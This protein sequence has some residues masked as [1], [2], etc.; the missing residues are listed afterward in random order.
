MPLISAKTVA[1]ALASYRF[2]PSSEQLTAA[3]RWAKLIRDGLIE[4][5]RETALE[6]DFRR[7]IIEDILGYCSVGSGP[8]FTVATK[9]PVG[10]GEVDLALGRFSAAERK[11]L[12]PF[13]LK[14]PSFKN[15]D[16]IMPG[17]AKT[18]VQQAWEYG[19]DAIGA[20]WVLVSNQME[21]RLYA[22]GRGRRD[23]EV[24]D[25]S[26]LDDPAHLKR[27][28]MLLAE[29]NLLGSLTTSLLQR[30]LQEDKQITVSLYKDYNS[31]RLTLIDVINA[32]CP[33]ADPDE[34]IRLAQKLLD[35]VL[36]IAFAED[37]VLLP[38]NQLRFAV[39]FSDPFEPKPKWNYL[40]S[41]FSAVDKGNPRLDIPPYNG[42]L[43]APDAALDV[44]NI[45]DLTCD[46]LA[47]LSAYDFK[48][49]VSVTIL[50]HIFE[51]SITDIERLQTQVHGKD[52]PVKTKR[53]REGIVY[54]PDFVTRFIVEK[55]LG[56]HLHEVRAKLLE[57]YAD[58]SDADGMI[59]WRGKAGERDFW[60][61]Y[62]A[63]IRALKI[64]DPAC[65]SGAFLIAAFDFLRSEQ[66]HVRSRLV[67][68]EPGLLSTPERNCIG[69]PE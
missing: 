27:F 42:G 55:T 56:A 15:L 69:G 9:E 13:E 29:P 40:K 48:S 53:K 14:G 64:V 51:Q 34:V 8:G 60:H 7:Y 54:T 31:L 67:E 35:R 16:T 26:K 59:Q 46:Q 49:Q 28:Y 39:S 2:E 68:L 47:S 33:N 37:T 20:R 21:I 11:I 61:A 24:F 58:G 4:K 17:R 44:L 52:A 62:L 32:E 10:N 43:F 6:A 50:G 63:V 23:Y 19:I 66:E 12:A 65:G 45:P 41:L 57:E 22:M 25:L 1:A 38:D 36:F 3:Q 18:P 30:S 5:V